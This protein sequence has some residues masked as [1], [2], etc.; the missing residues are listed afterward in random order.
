MRPSIRLWSSRPADGGTR[1]L[2][3]LRALPPRHIKRNA[4]RNARLIFRSMMIF[5]G[6]FGKAATHVSIQN[7]NCRTLQFAERSLAYV[8]LL[9]TLTGA[10][11]RFGPATRRTLRD[12][13]A[14]EHQDGAW[15]TAHTDRTLRILELDSNQ[16][17]TWRARVYSSSDV[18]PTCPQDCRDR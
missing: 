11:R 18:I 6:K 13:T 3:Q 16:L 2:G 1:C 9:C 10:S 15:I 14:L 7:F 5:L 4:A 12:L 8:I 17:A